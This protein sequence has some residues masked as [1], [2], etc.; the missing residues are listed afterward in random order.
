MPQVRIINRYA[1]IRAYLLKAIK[2]VGSLALLWSTVVLLGG[3]VT[4]LKKKD[5]SCLTLIGFMQ[6]AGGPSYRAGSAMAGGTEAAGARDVSAEAAGASSLAI[7]L[8]SRQPEGHHGR[9]CD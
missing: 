6:A 7:G 8:P 1:V 9:T 3:F 4:A 2:L 5:F